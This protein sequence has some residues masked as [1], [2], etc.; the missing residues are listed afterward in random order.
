MKSAA[1]AVDSSIPPVAFVPPTTF[2]AQL[3]AQAT[4][5]P[6]PLTGNVRPAPAAT[7]E[8]SSPAPRVVEEPSSDAQVFWDTEE[9]RKQRLVGE[10]L[11]DSL[12]ASIEEELGYKLPAA[13]V[14]L[15]H[16]QN[17]GIPRS[18]CYNKRRAVKCLFG[19]SRQPACSLAGE[20]GS[21]YRIN[22]EGYPPMGVY[23]ADCP[24]GAGSYLFCLDYRSCGPQ[25]EPRVLS[26]DGGADF[27]VMFVA[28][29]FE[30]FIEG[31]GGDKSPGPKP[32]TD[33]VPSH[34]PS[35]ALPET[36]PPSMNEVDAAVHPSAYLPNDAS[37]SPSA[38]LPDDASVNPS[39]YLPDDAS[40]NPSAYLPDDASVSPSDYLPDAA[41]V[42]PSAY[43]PDGAPSVDPS[44]YLSE[45]VHYS[46]Y[47]LDSAADVTGSPRAYGAGSPHAS[48]PFSL[49]TDNYSF[50]PGWGHNQQSAKPEVP[51][52]APTDVSPKPFPAP[53]QPFSFAAMAQPPT[54]LA[55]NQVPK[56]Q[57]PMPVTY[58]TVYPT[59]NFNP[60]PLSASA[61][62]YS[63]ASSNATLAQTALP[64]G[65]PGIRGY[66]SQSYATINPKPLTPSVVSPS[67][68]QAYVPA[69]RLPTST[70][71]MYPPYP[72]AIA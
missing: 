72:I 50:L 2:A 9:S 61:P 33:P 51:M 44:S 7:L 41:S 64:A 63:D 10:P 54:Y 12:V 36:S 39:A 5:S 20:H 70:P 65:A 16:M 69:S 67:S 68:A 24:P 49:P 66:R 38:Y 60:L 47:L 4:S 58:P 53:S 22:T 14:Q 28:K 62:R 17:G 30:A 25:G 13:Y 48:E 57:A 6:P 32:S 71:T 55:P 8:P 19:I 59:T 15:M 34:T 21:R 52:H 31:L 37:V 46:G 11:T 43:L 1:C 56:P 26:V 45:P 27:D 3:A 23:F 29:T 18:S 42:S 40:I 35:Q